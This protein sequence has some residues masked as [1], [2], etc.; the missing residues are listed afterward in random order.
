MRFSKLILL[1]IMKHI[2]YIHPSKVD[3]M[4]VNKIDDDRCR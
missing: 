1:I 4:G 3:L 2:V